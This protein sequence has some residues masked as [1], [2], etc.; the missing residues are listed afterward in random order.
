MHLL[1]TSS[2]IAW[3]AP[4]IQLF[5]ENSFVLKIAA[6]TDIHF[7]T[8]RQK[9]NASSKHVMTTISLSTLKKSNLVPKLF[10]L[11]F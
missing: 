3:D 8:Y 7:Q 4:S 1:D 2:L 10:L 9:L 11:V 5:K 6:F